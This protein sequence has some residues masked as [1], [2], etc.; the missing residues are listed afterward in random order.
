ML[1]SNAPARAGTG[2]ASARSQRGVVLIVA[3]VVL[4]AMSLG[5]IAIMRSVDTSTLIAGNIAFK[6]RTLAGADIGLETA[7][8][9]IADNRTNLN[10]D[11]ASA[12]YYSSLSRVVGQRFAWESPTAWSAAKD[13]GTDASGNQIHYIIHRM[14]AF[15][16]LS[17]NNPNQMCATDRGAGEAV[18]AA[19]GEGASAVAG[20][21]GYA[22]PPQIYV[23][24]TVRSA[25]P[26]NAVSYVQAMVLV[27]VPQI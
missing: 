12:A 6:Q 27:P 24:V 9:W 21:P 8:K 15:P 19:P 18:I 11:N 10:N 2:R 25:G 14:C 5:G 16:S 20:G 4:V 7:I 13:V 26:R 1:N 23:R 22:T 3:L 17:F